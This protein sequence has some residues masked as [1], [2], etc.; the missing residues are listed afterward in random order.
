M[1]FAIAALLASLV[2]S[3]AAVQTRAP[4]SATVPITLDHNRIIIDVYFPI[5]DGSKIRVRGWVDPGDTKIS[6]TEALAKKLG[7]AMGKGK[8]DER[9]SQVPRELLVGDMHIDLSELKEATAFSEE[10][11]APGSSASIKLPAP[12]LRHYDVLIDYL[13]REFTIATTGSVHFEGTEIHAAVGESTGLLQMECD[14]AGQKNTISFDPGTSVS[15]ISG[16]SLAKWHKAHPTWPSMVG[17]VGPAN[18]W[19]LQSEPAWQVLRIPAIECGSV[20]LA[21]GIAVPFD[22]E[23]LDWYQKRAGVPTVGLIGADVLLNFRVGM[24][25]AHSTVYFKQLSKYTPPGLDVVGVTLKPEEDGRYTII[26]VVERGRKSSVPDVKVGDTLMTVDNARVK[27]GTMGQ[28]WS[29]LSGNPGDI[30]TLGLMR[31]GHPLTVKAIVY[32]F[33]PAVKMASKTQKH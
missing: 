11:I 15:W 28:A 4:N 33:L 10:S 27:G 26:G 12:V 21:N 2:A 17:A 31:D 22:K 18:L 20:A 14:I 3:L 8:Q 30:R 5:P 13:N 29:L 9:K 1:K 32:R 24:D 19:G 16:E 23:T 25:Y 6:I 7:L